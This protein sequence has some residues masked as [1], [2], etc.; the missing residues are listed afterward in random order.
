MEV[1]HGY[2]YDRIDL[3]AVNQAVWEAAEQRP[4]QARRQFRT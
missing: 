4:A 3:L 1:C 2:N